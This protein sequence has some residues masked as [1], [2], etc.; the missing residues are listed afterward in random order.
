MRGLTRPMMFLATEPIVQA[1]TAY[2]A[3]LYGKH[4]TIVLQST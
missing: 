4:R 2:Q 3:A 1:I